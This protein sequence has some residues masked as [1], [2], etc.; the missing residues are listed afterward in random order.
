MQNFESNSTTG[1]QPNRSKQ[2]NNIIIIIIIV[3]VINHHQAFTLSAF[4]IVRHSIN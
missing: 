4:K 2:I 1:R 3:V